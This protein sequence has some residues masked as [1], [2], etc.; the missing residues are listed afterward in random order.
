MKFDLVPF[1]FKKLMW[2]VRNVAIVMEL[3]ML[4]LLLLMGVFGMF[5]NTKTAITFSSVFLMPF[6]LCMIPGFLYEK[7]SQ[8]HVEFTTNR[9]RVSDRHGRC[10]R[11]IPYNSITAIRS[12]EI[13]GFFYG[14]DREKVVAKY[15]CFFLNGATEIPDVSYAKLYKSDDIFIVG[16]QEAAMSFI[17]THMGQLLV[18]PETK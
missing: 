5:A 3:V 13:A 16:Y 4:L 1:G 9:L 14:K 8:S 10:W 15:I 7:I 12:D 2:T 11:E 18:P 17:K 6:T